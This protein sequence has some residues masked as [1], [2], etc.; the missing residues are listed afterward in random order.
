MPHALSLN[1]RERRLRYWFSA[2]LLL[3]ALGVAFATR[4]IDFDSPAGLVFRAVFGLVTAVVVIGFYFTMFAEAMRSEVG[5]RGAACVALFLVFPVGSAFL[6]YWWTRRL[7]NRGAH[8][9]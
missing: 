9:Q 6:Y 3:L 8:Y 4:G 5:R 2:A 1:P 7:R